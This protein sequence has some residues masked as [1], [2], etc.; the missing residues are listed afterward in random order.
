MATRVTVVDAFATDALSGVPF[1]VTPDDTL[2]TN[3]L[4]ALAV[5]LGTSGTVTIED[6]D[7]RYVPRE[8]PEVHSE[9]SPGLDSFVGAAVAGATGLLEE[10]ALEPET[11]TFRIDGT[12]SPEETAIEIESDRSVSV[13]LEEQQ[14]EETTLTDED[15][16]EKLT[17][18]SDALEELE[19]DLPCSIVSTAGGTLFVPVP[20]LEH[21]SGMDL[22]R[23]DLTSLCTQADVERVCALT[24]DTLAA[25]TDVH[26]RIFDPRHDRCERPANGIVSGGCGAYLAANNAFGSDRSSIR[27]ESGQFLDR[28]STVETTLAAVPRVSGHALIVLEGTVTV[29]DD[30]DDEIIVV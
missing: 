7:I 17:L 2:S 3:Q 23:E 24:F 11:A 10:R 25:E 26:V 12:E 18:P 22:T 13:P 4:R 19:R 8:A 30:E 6:G 28:P 5:E 20:F 15:I 29:P 9:S 27:I 16:T 14:L 21:L 1:V